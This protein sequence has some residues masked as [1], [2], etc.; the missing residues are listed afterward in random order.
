[1]AAGDYA[2]WKYRLGLATERVTARLLTERFVAISETVKASTIRTLGVAPA[3]IDVVY[4]AVRGE[5]LGE[6]RRGGSGPVLITTGRL[7]RH[8][9]QDLLIRMLPLVRE[10]WPTCVLRIVGDGTQR[11]VLERLAGEVGVAANVEFLGLRDDVAHLLGEA[12]VYVYASW[13]EGFANAFAEAVARGVP[14]V[15]VDLPV[16]KEI[17]PPQSVLLVRRDERAL[18]EAVLHVLSDLQSFREVARRNSVHFRERFSIARYVEGVEA[19]Y[20]RAAAGHGRVLHGAL[21]GAGLP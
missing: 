12:D 7:V 3:R 2:A 21:A 17:A 5:P 9:G 10:Q 16:F 19:V 15:A 6:E 1:V 11:G 8:K 18:A 4:R 20:Q 13:F 14:V